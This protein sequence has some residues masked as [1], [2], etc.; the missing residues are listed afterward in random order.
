MGQEYNHKKPSFLH[1]TLGGCWF[2]L[3]LVTTEKKNPINPSIH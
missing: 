2:T 1:G 3:T